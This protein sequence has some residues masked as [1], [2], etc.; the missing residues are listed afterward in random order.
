MRLGEKSG[1][2]PPHPWIK[3]LTVAD[4][5]T[6]EAMAIVPELYRGWP[7]ATRTDKA[8]ELCGNAMVT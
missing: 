5:A 2:R 1:K 3:N 4:D 8:K 6:R 7:Q